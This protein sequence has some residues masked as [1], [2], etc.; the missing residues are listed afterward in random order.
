MAYVMHIWLP[1]DE[2]VYIWK[3]VMAELETMKKLEQEA[4]KKQRGK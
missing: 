4:L 2:Y 1:E 3:R